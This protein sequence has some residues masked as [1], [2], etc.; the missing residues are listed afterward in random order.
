MGESRSRFR[1]APAT[2]RRVTLAAL[3]ALAFIVVTGGAVRLT[4]SGL[5]CPDW[6]TCAQDRLIP[7]PEAGIHAMVEFVNRAITGLVSL[8]VMLA[9]LG[10]LLRRPRRRDL[11]WLSLGLVAGVIGQIVLGGLTVLFDLQPQFVMGHF[12]LSMVLLA[13][14][15]VLWDRAGESEPASS[16]D[17]RTGEIDGGKGPTSPPADP[18]LAGLGRGTVAAGAIVLFLGTVVTAS[19]PHGGDPGAARL[20]LVVGDMARLH[21]LAV[22]V[23]LAVAALTCWRAPGGSRAQG[24]AKVVLGL[25]VAQAGVGYLQY[26]TGVPVLLVGFHIAGASAVWV[27]TVVLVRSTSA[28]GQHQSAGPQGGPDRMTTRSVR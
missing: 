11:T 8:A 28:R 20:P 23:F 10:S 2:Y 22:V 6:P 16:G 24:R 13:N 1:L 21:G 7:V 9:V 25:S 18:V 3:W 15:A 26:F 14:A 5:G 19:G 4:G 27:A 17:G 12:L